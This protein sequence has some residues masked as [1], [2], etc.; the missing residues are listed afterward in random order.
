V[1]VGCTYYDT[2]VMLVD[3]L[4]VMQWTPLAVVVSEAVGNNNA[5]TLAVRDGWWQGEL[6]MGN[7]VWH[8]SLAVRGAISNM[9]SSEFAT[10]YR[11][12]NQ[13]EEV[14]Y[15]GAANF[16]VGVAYAAA[17]E[18]AQSLEP[19]A[20][21]AALE[22][23]NV[24]EFYASLNFNQ[25]HQINLEMLVAQ[26]AEGNVEEEIVY[27]YDKV[28]TGSMVFPMPTWAKRV[29]K[30]FGPA[31]WTSANTSGPS[32]YATA[33]RLTQECS[34]NGACSEAGTCVCTAGYEGALCE[35]TSSFTCP[36]GEQLHE[37][38]QGNMCQACP[39]GTYKS[40]TAAARCDACPGGELI[41]TTLAEG[42]TQ[43]TQ[44]VC[45]VGFLRELSGTSTSDCSPCPPRATCAI[46]TTWATLHVNPGGWR[47]SEQTTTIYPCK[48][49]TVD[50]PNGTLTTSPCLGGDQVGHNGDGYCRPEVHGPLCEE[51]KAADEFFDEARG[52]CAPCDDVPNLVGVL[53]V[54][55]A[56]LMLILVCVVRIV[57]LH[58]LSLERTSKRDAHLS[59]TSRCLKRVT[60]AALW[61]WK[62]YQ[63]VRAAGFLSK[64][65]ILVSFLGIWVSFT[66]TP[67]TRGTFPIA[68]SSASRKSLSSR[69][70]RPWRLTQVSIPAIYGVEV[71][72]SL[73]RFFQWLD[74]F[75]FNLGY[76][77][78]PQC[79]GSRVQRKV[80]VAL[81][82]LGVCAIFPPCSLLW[83][84]LGKVVQR[85]STAPASF[86]QSCKQVL[87]QSLVMAATPTVFVL[88]CV[89]PGVSRVIFESWDCEPFQFSPNEV[90]RYLRSSQMS[91]DSDE[92]AD[93]QMASR[94][95][96]GIW[97][98]SVMV[99]FV[100][101]LFRNRTAIRK[102]LPTTLSAA[103]DVLC[104]EYNVKYF[105]CATAAPKPRVRQGALADHL[106]EPLR[107]QGRSLRLPAACCSWGC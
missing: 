26:I 106:F 94:G 33:T 41:A 56:S 3:A 81:I 95:L 14:T 73:L 49:A 77:V 101:L 44:C 20:V 82:P 65:K 92:Y 102:G 10:R 46:N 90:R 29:C 72:P 23:I 83:I 36:P 85:S 62:T 12:A 43:D 84:V 99:S 50:S 40:A 98:T 8:R 103:S 93:L 80:I 75:A 55:Y 5:W 107:R 28:T 21:A 63:R 47:L 4:E 48:T 61:V 34:G 54:A 22:S 70:P 51:C 18:Q 89:T 88:Y 76:I 91:C 64:L 57:Q 96:I 32:A 6:L 37:S 78:H 25:N 2:A 97:P 67:P 58:V 39:V 31:V 52:Q 71:P 100:L 60:G 27:P 74:V 7:V 9:T 45:A 53:S 38:G 69:P 42:A 87:F 68:T 59:R 30:R 35:R 24:P 15:H 1:I 104:H 16:A 79:V 19:Y 17:I 13:G 105:Y 11:D 66:G 86:L